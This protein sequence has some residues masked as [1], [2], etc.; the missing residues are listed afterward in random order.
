MDCWS[1]TES[2]IGVG[3]VGYRPSLG[4]IGKMVGAANLADLWR[5]LSPAPSP[6]CPF[7]SMKISRVSSSGRNN[8][9]GREAGRRD[10][11]AQPHRFQS[12]AKDAL[13][14]AK[15]VY[16]SASRRENG[17]DGT[18]GRK[19]WDGRGLPV[20]GAMELW[21]GLT[22]DDNLAYTGFHFTRCERRRSGRRGSR[23]PRPSIPPRAS[24]PRHFPREYPFSYCSD[25]LGD[26]YA[27]Q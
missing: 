6:S 1:P 27:P 8:R 15:L 4:G 21:S 14:L 11:L 7:P 5:R 17:G 16:Q 9:A 13:F 19:G 26:T 10:A 2:R 23:P 20:C 22:R 12:R 25:S 24:H 3:G 18:G